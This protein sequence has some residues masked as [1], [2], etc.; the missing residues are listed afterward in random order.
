MIVAEESFPNF[1]GKER[2]K[3]ESFTASLILFRPVKTVFVADE[4]GD[5]IVSLAVG[6]ISKNPLCVLFPLRYARSAKLY[7]EQNPHIRTVL[8]EG[9][10]SEESSPSSDAVGD[11]ISG[12]YVYKTDVINDFYR[13]GLTAAAIHFFYEPED[14]N[15]DKTKPGDIAVFLEADI[16]QVKETFSKAFADFEEI[17]RKQIKKIR[18]KKEKEE[19]KEKKKIEKALEKEQRALDRKQKAQERK[20]KRTEK[21]PDSEESQKKEDASPPEKNKIEDNV[22]AL[23]ETEKEEEA[24]ILPNIQF[25]ASLTQY[26]DRPNLSC[27]VLV[28]TAVDYFDKNVKIPIIYFSWLNPKFMPKEVVVIVNDSPWI[29]AIPAVKMVMAGEAKGLFLSKFLLSDAQKFDKMTL[30]KIRKTW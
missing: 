29:Q 25:Y 7:R 2:I 22:S 5:D 12:Y 1:Y 8:L 11:E 13:A 10:Y 15:I 3:N 6:E 28:D 23:K 9:R 14:R 19:E 18:A 24:I 17:N 27:V 16:P 21:A 30:R 26:T 4:A 20:E